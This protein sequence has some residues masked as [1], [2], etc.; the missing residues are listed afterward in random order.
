[1]DKT[2]IISMKSLGT[3]ATMDMVGQETLY[4]IAA[5]WAEVNGDAQYKKNAEYSRRTSSTRTSWG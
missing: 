2:W 5:Y 3:C 4:H 1:M